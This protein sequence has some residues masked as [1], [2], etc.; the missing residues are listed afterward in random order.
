[1]L[2]PAPLGGGT[3]RR[4]LGTRPSGSVKSAGQ[5]RAGIRTV[6]LPA[7]NRRDLEDI[8]ETV[9]ARLEIVWAEKIEDVLGAALEPRPVQLAAA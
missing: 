3:V 8:P 5:A 7:R 1:M 6:I 4:T 9:R 2:P